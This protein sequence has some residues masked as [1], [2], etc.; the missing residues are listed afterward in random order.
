MNVTNVNVM[1]ANVKI[2][3]FVKL[4]IRAMSVKE[5]ITALLYYTHIFSFAVGQF[6]TTNEE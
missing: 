3:F 1:F 4:L 5:R 2:I 6:N